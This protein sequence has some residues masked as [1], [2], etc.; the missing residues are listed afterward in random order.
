MC[1]RDREG[2]TVTISR[3]VLNL[4]IFLDFSALRFLIMLT[5]C[6]AVYMMTASP[7]FKKPF[8]ENRVVNKICAYALTG[9]FI[10]AALFLTNVYRY[11]DSN[12]SLK[13][14]FSQESGNQMTQELV[15]AFEAGQVSL[16][17]LS[18]IHI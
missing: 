7:V 16:L 4:P 2:E 11:S 18:L 14:D 15:D 5:A 6:M 9:V 12:H 10:L 17:R 1:I 3:I 13:K 8:G